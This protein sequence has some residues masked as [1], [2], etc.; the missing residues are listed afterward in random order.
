MNSQNAKDYLPFV[1]ALA[2]GKELQIRRRGFWEDTVPFGDFDF[3]LPA[4]NY[5][6]KPEPRRFF[7]CPPTGPCHGTAYR[8]DQ[9]NDIMRASG[10]WV[11]CMEV[12]K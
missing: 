4:S 7:V 6:I 3:T 8:P 9:M 5:R 12:V 1:Q 10:V 2:E 11:E